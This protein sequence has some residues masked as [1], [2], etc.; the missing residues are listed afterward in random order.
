[1]IEVRSHCHSANH[2]APEVIAASE[3]LATKFARIRELVRDQRAQWLYFDRNLR[4]FEGTTTFLLKPLQRIHW[5][6]SQALLDADA[7][8]SDILTQ[9]T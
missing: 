5:L 9:G 8:I 1:M 2:I 4:I 7:I 6:R 3:Q